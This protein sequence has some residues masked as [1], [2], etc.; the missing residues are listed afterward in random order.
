MSSKGVEKRGMQMEAETSSGK[1][2]RGT[3]VKFLL[4]GTKALATN[5]GL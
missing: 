1:R 5:I 2:K 4:K 3:N